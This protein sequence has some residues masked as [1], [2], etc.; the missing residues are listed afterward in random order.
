VECKV[1]VVVNGEGLV[2]LSV[3]NEVSEVSW[4]GLLCWLVFW[5][6]HGWWC[7]GSGHIGFR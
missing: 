5:A 7:G 2:A 3:E 1:G 4:D 6:W